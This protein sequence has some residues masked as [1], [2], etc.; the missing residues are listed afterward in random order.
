V[1]GNSDHAATDL[2]VLYDSEE[3]VIRDTDT[4]YHKQ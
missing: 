2:H 1:L 4:I 3:N